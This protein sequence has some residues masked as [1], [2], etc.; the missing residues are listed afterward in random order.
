MVAPYDPD[1]H[2]RES[3]AVCL[4]FDRVLHD[5]NPDW[6]FTQPFLP[7]PLGTPRPGALELCKALVEMGL[8]IVVYS[9][10]VTFHTGLIGIQSWLK[11]YKFPEA[12]MASYIPDYCLY[13]STIAIPW[14]VDLQTLKSRVTVLLPLLVPQT[15]E[16]PDAPESDPNAQPRRKKAK[17]RKS[18]RSGRKAP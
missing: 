12:T 9:P 18:K 8:R 6:A 17:A 14:P 5:G 7:N 15:S 2:F 1:A 13:L 10:R 3:P 11:K 4:D 16:T